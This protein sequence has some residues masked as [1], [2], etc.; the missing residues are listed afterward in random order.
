MTGA[1]PARGARLTGSARPAHDD[2]LA[3][4]GALAR[5]SRLPCGGR[6]LARHCRFGTGGRLAADR[7]VATGGRA[8]VGDR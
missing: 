7:W 5:G 8:A 6:R 4:A 2:G 1:R 3:R